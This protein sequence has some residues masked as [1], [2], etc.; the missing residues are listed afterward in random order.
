MFKK[1]VVSALTL[2]GLVIGG[3]SA[4]ADEHDRYFGGCKNVTQN[5]ETNE[6]VKSCVKIF[7]NS[8]LGPNVIKIPKSIPY[9]DGTYQGILYLVS[10][11]NTM[12]SIVANYEG[13]LKKFK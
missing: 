5:V 4:H 3:I 8:P 1:I 13:T 10:Q 6:Y 9:D 7:P 12:Y 11:N 2:G